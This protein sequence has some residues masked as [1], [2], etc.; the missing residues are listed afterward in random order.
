MLVTSKTHILPNGGW[1]VLV[2]YHR[3]K[4]PK[5]L[6]Q[7]NHIHL[8]LKTHSRFK[9]PFLMMLLPV[10]FIQT[11]V[12]ICWCLSLSWLVN[13]DSHLV[14]SSH[15]NKPKHTYTNLWDQTLLLFAECLF[16]ATA[17]SCDPIES[18]HLWINIVV[19]VQ[20]RDL[21]AKRQAT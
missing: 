3:W 1:L 16:I 13:L 9:G 11:L 2:L 12:V 19:I 20:W 17:T 7:Q 6:K 15:K 14:S 18:C 5:Q 8:I 21:K 10:A 4:S